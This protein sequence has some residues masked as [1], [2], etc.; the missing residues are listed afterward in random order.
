MPNPQLFAVKVLSAPSIQL[1]KAMVIGD[2]AS[3]ARVLRNLLIKRYELSDT[4]RTLDEVLGTTTNP[5]TCDQ[6]ELQKAETLAELRFCEARYDAVYAAAA[7]NDPGDVEE[8]NLRRAIKAVDRATANTA[9]T[10]TLLI[11]IHNL[12]VAFPAGQT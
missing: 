3:R 9:A 4:L 6:I 12:V 7:F 8:D 1:F 11:A 10:A 2:A 5:S